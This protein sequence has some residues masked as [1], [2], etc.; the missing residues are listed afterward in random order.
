MGALP[1]EMASPSRLRMSARNATTCDPPATRPLSLPVTVL[2]GEGEG[3]PSGLRGQ[4]GESPK[5]A[6]AVSTDHRRH[7]RTRPAA[8]RGGRAEVIRWHPT[9]FRHPQP[10]IQTLH[11]MSV[12]EGV[13]GVIA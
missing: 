5:T 6:A 9:S 13:V 4:R 7:D 3:F 11:D 12:A 2:R 8:V 10:R 1:L